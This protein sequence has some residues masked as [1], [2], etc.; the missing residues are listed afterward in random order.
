MPKTVLGK[1]SVTK[2]EAKKGKR[3]GL[4]TKLK[5]L[6]KPRAQK[7][8]KRGAKRV[9]IM[10]KLKRSKGGREPDISGSSRAGPKWKKP[11]S[12]RASLQAQ[13]FKAHEPNLGPGL[14]IS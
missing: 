7:R 13:N 4:K 3:A 8:G 10:T 1:K 9:S 5:K 14:I 12:S 6:S 11:G 2:N